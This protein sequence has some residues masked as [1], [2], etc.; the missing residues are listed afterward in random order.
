MQPA[1]GTAC[2]AKSTAAL[3]PCTGFYILFLFSF[4][5]VTDIQRKS[6]LGGLVGGINRIHHGCTGDDLAC[7]IQEPTWAKDALEVQ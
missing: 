1:Q 4:W 2:F 5:V 7:G 6:S 3:F